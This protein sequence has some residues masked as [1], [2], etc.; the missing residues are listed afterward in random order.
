MERH[1]DTEHLTGAEAVVTRRRRTKETLESFVAMGDRDTVRDGR[2]RDQQTD[3][4]R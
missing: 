3:G 1:P 4:H 2:L